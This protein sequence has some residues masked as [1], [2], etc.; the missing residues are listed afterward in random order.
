MELDANSPVPVREQ[1]VNALREAI[2]SFELKPGQ[3]LIE[4][5]FIER[6]GIRS[7]RLVRDP[8]LS[9][10]PCRHAFRGTRER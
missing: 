1:T 9:R 2:L 7:G 10:V 4:R 3:R 6:L 8:G 5:E